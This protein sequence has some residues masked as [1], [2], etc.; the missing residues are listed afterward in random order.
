MLQTITLWRR[1]AIYNKLFF[2]KVR[3]FLIN[4][5]FFRINYLIIVLIKMRLLIFLLFSQYGLTCIYGI[6][7]Q[8][9]IYNWTQ[10]CIFWNFWHRIF[11]FLISNQNTQAIST[12]CNKSDSLFHDQRRDLGLVKLALMANV[13][14]NYHQ[15]GIEIKQLTCVKQIKSDFFCN[16]WNQT[17]KWTKCLTSN[18]FSEAPRDQIKKVTTFAL[19]F[20][21]NW[22]GLLYSYMLL[23]FDELRCCNSVTYK[24]RDK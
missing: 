18:K 16:S 3:P 13:F 6:I 1:T 10:N 20:D 12:C 23:L 9:L 14:F 2:N 19:W 22:Y 24:C 8:I 17:F 7:F 5:L 11:V 15:H 21:K 4:Y